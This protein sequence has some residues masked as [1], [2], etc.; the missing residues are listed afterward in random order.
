MVS[1]VWH[2]R[3]QLLAGDDPPENSRPLKKSLEEKVFKKKTSLRNVDLSSTFCNRFRNLHQLTSLLDKLLTQVVIRAQ[4]GL[5][6]YN[7]TIMTGNVTRITD[8]IILQMWRSL[9]WLTPSC[10][11]FE[12]VHW[13]GRILCWSDSVPHTINQ[14][15]ERNNLETEHLIWTQIWLKTHMDDVM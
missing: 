14:G 11:N 12:C 3:N 1:L 7:A 15:T 8:P 2:R 10:F 5:S 4:Q 9:G 13:V 6:N